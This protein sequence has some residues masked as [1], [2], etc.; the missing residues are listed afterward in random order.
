[1][2]LLLDTHILIW[3]LENNPRLPSEAQKA[4]T[5]PSN[6]VYVSAI[7]VWEIGIKKAI[8]KLTIPDNLEEAL[9]VNRFQLLPITISHALVAGKL[10][11]LHSD[12]FDRMLVA[13]AQVEI[14]TIV[15]VDDRIKQYNVN[16]LKI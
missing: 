14:L 8:G 13:Q 2:N 4:I 10:P 9:V 16:Y 12:P 5:E 1:M 15:T 6:L 11:L 7:T 3:W